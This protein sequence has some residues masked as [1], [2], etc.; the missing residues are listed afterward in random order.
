[1]LCIQCRAQIAQGT[2]GAW[3]APWEAREAR[4][5]AERP[6]GLVDDR[7][8]GP[9]PQKHLS[10]G[11]TEGRE[12]NGAEAGHFHKRRS[13]AVDGSV[14]LSRACGTDDSVMRQCGSAA[15][16]QLCRLL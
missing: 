9:F 3:A 16:A 14:S 6:R 8:E 1:M 2:R 5:A 4:V 15:D 13:G 11:G 12:R 10:N 7:S